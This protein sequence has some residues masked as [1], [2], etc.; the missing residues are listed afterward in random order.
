MYTH[1]DDVVA[2]FL[3]ALKS[4]VSLSTN[5]SSNI[6]IIAPDRA[7]SYKEWILHLSKELNRMQPFFHLPFWLVKPTIAIVDP[8]MNLGKRRAFMYKSSTIDRMAEDRWYSNQKAKDILGFRP[9]Y[10]LE[11]GLSKTVQH[12]VDRGLVHRWPI[13]PFALITCACIFAVVWWICK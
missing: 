13:S 4:P 3:A 12:Y 9:R 11:E 2:G 7:L 1:V 8:I 6:F 10:S 5:A